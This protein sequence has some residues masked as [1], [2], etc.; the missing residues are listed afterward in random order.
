MIPTPESLGMRGNT[1][2][3]LQKTA[4]S[5]GGWSDG[6]TAPAAG[7]RGAG[8]GVDKSAGEGRTSKI[9]QRG[10]TCSVLSSTL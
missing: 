7:L 6:G 2:D 4:A 10:W 3:M 9:H 8:W 1:Q 5:R